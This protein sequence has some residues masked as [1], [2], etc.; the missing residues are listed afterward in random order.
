[1]R[2]RHRAPAAAK[3]VCPVLAEQP[4]RNLLRQ[5]DMLRIWP[6]LP[7]RRSSSWTRPTSSFAGRAS[8]SPSREFPNLVDPDARLSKAYALAGARLGT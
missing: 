8:L 6:A 7:E 2:S 4:D 1:M 5:A 3:L